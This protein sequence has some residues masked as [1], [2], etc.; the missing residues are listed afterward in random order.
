MVKPVS[1]ARLFDDD[2]R[3]ARLVKRADE[4]FI[5]HLL[6]EIESN[7]AAADRRGGKGLVRLLGKPGKSAAHGFTNALRQRGRIPNSATFVH[8]AQ[9]LNQEERVATCDGRQCPSQFFVVVAGLGDVRGHVVLI[10]AA[11]LKAV[12]GA[13]AGTGG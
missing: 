5:D 7:P 9:R 4:I 8:M 3:L 2:A 13:A 1:S 11:E 6:N 12:G 10:K